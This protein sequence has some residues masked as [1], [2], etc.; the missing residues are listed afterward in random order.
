MRITKKL[1][2]KTCLPVYYEVMKKGKYMDKYDFSSLLKDYDC[3]NGIYYLYKSITKDR[4]SYDFKL[5]Q[6][7]TH[8]T[9]QPVFCNTKEQMIDAINFRVKLL[10][11]WLK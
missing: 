11:S 2:A 9:T 10:E 1:V 8:Q 7:L 5:L 3:I 6:K 4:G